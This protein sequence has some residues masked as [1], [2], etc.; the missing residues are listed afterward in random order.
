[1]DQTEAL[2]T[3][4]RK[5]KVLGSVFSDP[6]LIGFL[7]DYKTGASPDIIYDIRRSIYDALGSAITVMDQQL[8]RGEVTSIKADLLQIRKQFA[9][10]RLGGC[11]R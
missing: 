6:E 4:K 3:M 9:P 1:M 10:P 8:K 5:C 7:D 11:V 2:T